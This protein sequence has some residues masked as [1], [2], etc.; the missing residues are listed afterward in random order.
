MSLLAPGA[1]CAACPLVDFLPLECSSCGLLFCSSHVHAHDPC[2]SSVTS[3]K[4]PGKLER[5]VSMCELKGCRNESIQ[6]IAGVTGEDDG[7]RIARGVN[8]LGCGGVFCATH[9]AQTSHSCS[10]P[11]IHNAR[12]DAF[13]DRRTKAQELISKQFPGHRDL[14]E[15]RLPQQRDVVKM[16]KLEGRSQPEPL[17]AKSDSLEEPRKTK[18]KAE[19]LWDIH[20]RKV[21]STATSLGHG[22]EIPL[23][24][25]K[26]FEWDVD[27]DGEKVKRWQGTGKWDG[28]LRRA[29]VENDTPVGKMADLIIA[30]AKVPRPVGQR[31]SI[32]QLYQKPGGPPT[33]LSLTLSHTA[34]QTITEGASLILVKDDQV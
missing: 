31:F 32:L 21:K 9:R 7:K 34:G 13:L 3:S 30:Q 28:K 18:T 2:S 5:G 33:C 16:P 22:N 26:F 19:K 8:C 29:W 25:K 23:E 20:L 1:K 15:R 6:S 27:L 4:K 11:L 14:P 10:S 17:P 24:D 12:H